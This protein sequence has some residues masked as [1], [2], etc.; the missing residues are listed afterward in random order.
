M[1]KQDQ[2]FEESLDDIICILNKS[3]NLYSKNLGPDILKDKKE[4]Q[5]NRYSQ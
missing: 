3:T 2:L 1:D 4:D 5:E